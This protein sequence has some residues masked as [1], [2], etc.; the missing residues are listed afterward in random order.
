[1]IV[2][3]CT[4]TNNKV[5]QALINLGLIKDGQSVFNSF[6]DKDFFD[7]I[8]FKIEESLPIDN[9]EYYS[10]RLRKEDYQSIFKSFNFT[11]DEI[12]SQRNYLDAYTFSDELYKKD[13]TSEYLEEIEGEAYTGSVE[14]FPKFTNHGVVWDVSSE[15]WDEK[16]YR[17]Y[18]GI[19]YSQLTGFDLNQLIELVID[20]EINDDVK[21]ATDFVEI[22]P[23]WED[24]KEYVYN[25]IWEALEDLNEEE[26]LLGRLIR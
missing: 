11:E 25:E 1:M 13:I 23:D 22:Y 4:F 10:S 26:T 15:D 24:D 7:F 19:T 9:D 14:C 3:D 8:F 21:N 17:V 18:S 12:K 6:D 16:E 20:E 2:L 5:T